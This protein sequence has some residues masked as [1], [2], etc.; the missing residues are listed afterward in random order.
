M[1]CPKCTRSLRFLTDTFVSCDFCTWM[2][3]LNAA[4]FPEE[5]AK[6]PAA[7]PEPP[8]ADDSGLELVTA[9]GRLETIRKRIKDHY[10][11]ANVKFAGSLTKESAYKEGLAVV[12]D[13]VSA[14]IKDLQNKK[15]RYG[16]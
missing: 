5:P 3:S 11:Q 9:I 7:A 15:E 13:L 4:P 6:A 12:F 10:S 8:K 16:K 14:E 1:K 2:G